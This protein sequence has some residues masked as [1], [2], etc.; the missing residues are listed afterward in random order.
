MARRQLVEG[1]GRGR[2]AGAAPLRRRSA[3]SGMSA[4]H[5]GR[6][7]GLGRC[8]RSEPWREPPGHAQALAGPAPVDAEAVQQ[9]LETALAQGSGARARPHEVRGPDARTPLAAR[10]RCVARAPALANMRFP[11]LYRLPRH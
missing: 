5:W 9:A 7:E 10:L 8:L 1:R 11:P 4:L 6:S 2:E 3:L